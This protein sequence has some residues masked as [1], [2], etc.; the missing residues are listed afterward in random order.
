VRTVE[1]REW[2]Q[3]DINFCLRNREIPLFKMAEETAG[4]GGKMDSFLWGMEAME[5]NKE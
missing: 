4:Q 1:G 2:E 3:R 5:G